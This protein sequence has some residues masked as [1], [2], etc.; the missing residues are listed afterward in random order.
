MTVDRQFPI[1]KPYFERPTVLL[2]R[3]KV[4]YSQNLTVGYTLAS[5]W[6]LIQFFELLVKLFVIASVLIC[7]LF[8]FISF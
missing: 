2:Y 1:K 5:H 7:V 4:L 6:R 8:Y 3:G